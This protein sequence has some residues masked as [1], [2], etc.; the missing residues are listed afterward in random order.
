MPVLCSQLAGDVSHK[1]GRKLPL[2]SAM[3]AVT[4]ATL[5]RAATNFAAWWTEARCSSHAF[6]SFRWHH[7]RH[8]TRQHSM[9]S[10]D[11]RFTH[12]TKCLHLV[13]STCS[14][15]LRVNRRVVRHRAWLL[16]SPPARA[17][18]EDLCFGDVFK[19]Y[20]S[21]FCH[22]DYLNIFRAKLH[23]ICRIGRPLAEYQ[24]AKVIFC[25]PPRGV[26]VATNF[27]N[28]IHLPFHAL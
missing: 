12:V 22:T 1:P 8:L 28:K 15:S 3:P 5:K 2:L 7:N 25:D 27:V 10:S 23:E 11:L 4:P 17:G 16:V 9:L 21:D 24:R 14:D 6:V 13:T 26:A 20:F 19:K 18:E